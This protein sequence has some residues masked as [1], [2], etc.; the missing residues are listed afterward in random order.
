[1]R[2]TTVEE[3]ARAAYSA[4]VDVVRTDTRSTDALSE[5]MSLHQAFDVQTRCREALA[6][7]RFESVAGRTD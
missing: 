1:M 2:P 5:M 6:L 7:P 4:L 3:R